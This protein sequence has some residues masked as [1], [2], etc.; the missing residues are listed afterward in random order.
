MINF[1]TTILKFEKK[2]EKTGWTYLEIPG[3]IVQKLFPRNKFIFRVKGKIDDYAVKQVALLPIGNGRFI[4]ALNKAMRAGIGKKYGD[5]VELKIEID[6]SQILISPELLDCL[7]EESEALKNFN[8]L[9]PSHQR[10]F[11]NWVKEAKTF[12]TKAK[13]IA[14]TINALLKGYHYGEM[15]KEQRRKP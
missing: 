10:Y 15:I 9:V 7:N 5:V 12:E 14:L 11:S 8:K 1:T 13:R 2:G 6:K 4:M 3:D